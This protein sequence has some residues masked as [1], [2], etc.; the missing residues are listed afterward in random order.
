MPTGGGAV[1]EEREAGRGAAPAAGGRCSLR[2]APPR[3]ASGAWRLRW[4]GAAGGGAPQRRVLLKRPWRP[5]APTFWGSVAGQGGSSPWAAVGM[6]PGP[7]G[8]ARR[9][10][11]GGLRG[12]CFGAR[13]TAW[14]NWVPTG[15]FRFGVAASLFFASLWSLARSLVELSL[16]SSRPSRCFLLGCETPVLCPCA[17]V[18]KL[19]VKYNLKKA[20]KCWAL[21]MAGEVQGKWHKMSSPR[22]KSS[23]TW[24]LLRPKK[25]SAPCLL[26]VTVAA[27]LECR[28]WTLYNQSC[29]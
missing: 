22:N 23:K 2:P 20:L 21:L 14:A 7:T 8:C 3:F 24:L 18:R 10:A 29:K 6:Q 13:P 5:W 27:C 15:F 1:P 25:S 26:S 4:P 28:L 12:S 9:G 19:G 16:C 11:P 17:L